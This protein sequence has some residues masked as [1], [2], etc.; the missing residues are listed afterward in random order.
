MVNVHLFLKVVNIVLLFSC[1]SVEAMVL[2]LEIFVNLN[3]IILNL[4]VLENV[5]SKINIKVIVIYVL[6]SM[7]LFVVLMVLIIKM[8][9]CVDAKVTVENILLV[10]VQLKNLVLDVLVF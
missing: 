9:V 7:I 6:M 1:L 2:P 4:S 10:N 5:K 8:N 3:V